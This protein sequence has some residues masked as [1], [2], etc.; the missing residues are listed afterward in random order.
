M[1]TADAGTAAGTAAG[2]GTGSGAAAGT[3]V[4][5]AG[6]VDVMAVL[7]ALQDQLDDLTATVEAQQHMIDE[8]LRAHRTA[9]TPGR[10][11]PRDGS[12]RQGDGRR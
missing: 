3:R 7:A 1:S 10:P 9:G 5:A 8:L 12:G 4:G 2:S 11:A 6:G